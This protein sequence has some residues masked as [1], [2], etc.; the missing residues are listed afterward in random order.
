MAK[1]KAVTRNKRMT[2]KRLKSNVM[3]FRIS[4][5]ESH[6]ELHGDQFQACVAVGSGVTAKKTVTCGYGSNPRKALA[7]AFRNEAT[8]IAKRSGA[9]AGLGRKR[10][11]R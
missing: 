9:F 10:R 11:R 5:W 7:A 2:S 1:I 6:G 3:L 4:P 8:L